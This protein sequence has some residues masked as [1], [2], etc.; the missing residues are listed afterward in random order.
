MI[1]QT[2]TIH[3]TTKIH[4][5]YEKIVV[6]TKFSS[7]ELILWLGMAFC[8]FNQV[9]MVSKPVKLLARILGF[10]GNSIIVELT[11]SV[12]LIA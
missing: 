2:F 11:S 5:Q 3:A 1:L 7:Y 12:V 9:L 10:T 4:L 6:S 8:S